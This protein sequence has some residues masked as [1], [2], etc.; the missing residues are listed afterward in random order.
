MNWEAIGAVGELLGSVLVLLTLV[1]LAVQTRSINRQTKA[2]TLYTFVAAMAD[3]NLHIAQNPQTASVWR[4]GLDDVNSLSEDERMQF[5]MYM[6]QYA[7]FWSVM[8]K[9]QT[10][11]TLPEDQWL[12]VRNDLLSI[13]GSVGGLYFWAHGGR[14]AF[15]QEFVTY[16]DHVLQTQ[17]KPYDMARMTRENADEA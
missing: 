8:H 16:V 13:L 6:G 4:R 11:G 7:N 3:I 5:F 10:D 12:I 17:T 2:E 1:Y 14:E 15:D 9:L